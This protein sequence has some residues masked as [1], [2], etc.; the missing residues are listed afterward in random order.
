MSHYSRVDATGLL[1]SAPEEHCQKPSCTVARSASFA[2]VTDQEL[3]R[4][5]IYI[6]VTR[7]HIFL[8]LSPDLV[9]KG[10]TLAYF[11]FLEELSRACSQL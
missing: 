6:W 8:R 4:V 10:I 3:Q 11:V 5:D 1:F 7:G 9:H 2:V